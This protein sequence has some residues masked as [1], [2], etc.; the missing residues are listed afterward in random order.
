VFYSST[1][2]TVDIQNKCILQKGDWSA[3]TTRDV[4]IW[5]CGR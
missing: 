5:L 3:A 4:N 1:L 2:G